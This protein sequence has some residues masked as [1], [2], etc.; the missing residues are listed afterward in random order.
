MISFNE[1]LK[2]L[3]SAMNLTRRDIAEIVELGGVSVSKSRADMWM[4]NPASTKINVRGTRSSLYRE[5][6]E[7]E[8]TAFCAGLKPWLNELR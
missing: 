2:L 7:E 8:F 3:A 5:M 6:T 4:R 1:H